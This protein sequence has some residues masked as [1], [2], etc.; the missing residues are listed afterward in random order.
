MGSLC[1]G[2]RHGSILPEIKLL[3]HQ[4]KFFQDKYPELMYNKITYDP[5]KERV[6]GVVFPLLEEV[7]ALV[8]PR[9]IHIGHDEV[10]RPVGRWLRP[11]EKPLPAGLFLQHLLR[12]HAY[13]KER[14][15]DTWMW[16]D[17]LL[18]PD[19]FPGMHPRHLH[20]VLPGY[21]KP[22][23]DKV[24]REIVICDWHYI[25]EQPEFPSLAVMQKEGFRV[26]GTTWKKA[27]TI[28][29]FSSYAS[30]Q[31]AYGMMATSF[32]PQNR[33]WDAVEDMLRISGEALRAFR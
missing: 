25:D 30:E 20:G 10:A 19:E 11:G 13:L 5:A 7:V 29:N 12:I 22:L 28:R 1:P 14:G 23:R 15:I 3:T 17:M 16:G 33:K 18:S 32:H 27:K 24:P 31:G 26:I 6:Y 2:K 4:E 9:A 8:R 21:G